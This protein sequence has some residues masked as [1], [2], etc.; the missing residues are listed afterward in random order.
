MKYPLP[1]GRVRVIHEDQDITRKCY[2]ESLKMENIRNR[3]VNG[4]GV[5]L[6]GQTIGGSS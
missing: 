4:L 1:D 5:K 6:G 2:V 3:G